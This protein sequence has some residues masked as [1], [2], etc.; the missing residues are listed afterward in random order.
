M[1]SLN[2]LAALGD[3]FGVVSSWHPTSNSAADNVGTEIFFDQSEYSSKIRGHKIYP[4][5]IEE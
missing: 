4:K 2:V 5:F 1:S 3:C